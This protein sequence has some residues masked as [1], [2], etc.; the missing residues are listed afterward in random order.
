MDLSQERLAR[1]LRVSVR[2]VQR[3]ESDLRPNGWWLVRF[4]ELARDAA[5]PDLTEYFYLEFAREFALDRCRGRELID[6]IGR[7]AKKRR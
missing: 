7:L 4:A 1:Q 2:T 5:R 6:V 3:F